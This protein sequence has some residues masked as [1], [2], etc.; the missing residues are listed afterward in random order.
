MEYQ[1]DDGYENGV[2]EERG[3]SDAPCAGSSGRKIPRKI[4]FQIKSLA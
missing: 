4:Q 1:A 3:C 2:T